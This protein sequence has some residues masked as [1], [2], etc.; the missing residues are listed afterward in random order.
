MYA[1]VDT[2]T[3]GLSSTK[4]RIIELA[5]IGLDADGN[6]EWEWCS[7]INPERDTGHGLVIKVHQI[8]PPD[9]ADAPK[10]A[11]L[12]G[13]IADVLN[14]RV[15]IAH[16]ARFD[17]RMIGAEFERLGVDLPPVAQICT[18]EL[19][20]DC[21]YR[22]FTLE[23][24]CEILKIEMDGM[25]H[26]LADAR[27]TWRLAQKLYDFSHKGL[28]SEVKVYLDTLPAWPAIP[29]VTRESKTR[30]ILPNRK[31]VR[32]KSTVSSGNAGLEKSSNNVMPEI[33]TYS[34]DREQPES[35][36]LAAVEWV[37]EDREITIEQQQALKELRTELQLTE[38]K[39]HEIHMAFVCGL[40]GS[41][42]DDGEISKHEKFDLEVVGKALKLNEADI[43][44][45]LDN[46]TKLDLI[47][48]D[49]DLEVGMKVVFTGEMSIP[50]SKWGDRAKKAGLRVIGAVS[51]KTDYLVV[52][53]GETGSSKSLKARSIGVRVVSEQRFLRMIKRLE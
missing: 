22:P 48:R 34:V 16:N 46:P 53:F 25:H 13:H 2:E 23:S 4:D 28:Q 15:V 36:Y 40:A 47:N 27:A 1:V 17:L 31:T 45:A 42:W 9:V 14:G 7:L 19:A 5:I 24:C 51:G 41:M 38:D 12:A 33:E 18:Q 39:A 20:R 52:P 21:G 26:A 37:L 29:V 6:K 3:T 43:K 44:F 8:Y 10:F 30:P 11:D 49:Y 50:R 35:K 32:Q